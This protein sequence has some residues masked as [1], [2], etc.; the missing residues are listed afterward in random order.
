MIN[1]EHIVR[2]FSHKSSVMIS[3]TATE[4]MPA[5]VRGA[6]EAQ[7]ERLKQKLLRPVLES[8]SSTALA[9]EI[10]WAAN[11]AA[12]LAWLT[13]CPVLVLPTLLEEKICEAIRKWNKQQELRRR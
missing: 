11:E 12:A 4:M 13:V 6:V 1:V 9:K 3:M 5:S 8:V 2:N 7:I 10:A